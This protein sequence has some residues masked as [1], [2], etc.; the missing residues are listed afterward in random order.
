MIDRK[1]TPEIS[2]KIE[3]RQRPLAE[4]DVGE[5]LG[6]NYL[7]LV[8]PSGQ[9]VEELH[10]WQKNEWLKTIRVRKDIADI[11]QQ[12]ADSVAVEKAGIK[13]TKTSH[14]IENDQETA[15]VVKTGIFTEI[16][17][18]WDA[19]L[20]EAGELD[21]KNIRY[22]AL[23]T[24]SNSFWGTML[25]AMGFNPEKDDVHPRSKR[26]APGPAKDLR[27]SDPDPFKVFDLEDRSDLDAEGRDAGTRLAEED[28]LPV[29]T[30][31]AQLAV[32]AARRQRR[33]RRRR[34]IGQLS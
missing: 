10:G 20:V 33:R 2:W 23:I 16:R 29:P 25:R 9:V 24:N 11:G 27:K 6:H 5:L 22:D 3:S 4:N 12:P 7:V 32:S 31:L 21:E 19:A 1:I 14:A 13:R 34:R 15:V 30:A 28:G 26:F 8:S 18:S 17:K